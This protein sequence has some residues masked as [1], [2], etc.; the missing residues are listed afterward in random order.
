MFISS[1]IL[2]ACKWTDYS[3]WT[4]CSK[5]CGEGTQTRSRYIQRV[6]SNGGK[7]CTGGRTKSKSCTKQACPG[8]YFKISKQ[9][10]SINLP[11]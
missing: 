8:K 1:K 9:D 10:N 7:E 2:V 11:K 3:D 5:S 4:S 6:A